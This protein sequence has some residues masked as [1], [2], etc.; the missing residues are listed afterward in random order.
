MMQIDQVRLQPVSLPDAPDARGAD[1][2]LGRQRPREKEYR[3][4]DFLPV[5]PRLWGAKGTRC[6]PSRTGILK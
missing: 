2:H 4:D 6:F 3:F 5:L 1:A